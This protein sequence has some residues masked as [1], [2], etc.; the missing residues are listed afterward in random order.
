MVRMLIALILLTLAG[1]AGRQ[2]SVR[3]EANHR[4]TPMAVTVGVR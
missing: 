4:G 1:C 3:F 2:V